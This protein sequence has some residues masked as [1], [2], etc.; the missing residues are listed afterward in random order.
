MTTVFPISSATQQSTSNTPAPTTGTNTLN[1][2]HVLA[3]ARCGV[4]V[5]GPD[6][7]GGQHAVPHPDCAVHGGR[8][9]AE[10]PVV[11]ASDTDRVAGARGVVDDRP[12]RSRTRSSKRRPTVS[13]HRRHRPSSSSVRGSLPSDAAVGATA[14]CV[15]PNVYTTAGR[16]GPARPRRSRRPTSGW[17]VQASSNGATIGP[18][19][20]VT[21]DA[22]GDHHQRRHH[23]SRRARSTASAA[24]RQPTGPRPASSLGFGDASDPTRLQLSASASTI[25]VV[26]QNGNDGKTATG[27]VTGVHMTADGPQLVIGGQANP[28]HVGHRRA[29]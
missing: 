16:E 28:L 25:G 24:P 27:I 21:F 3:A 5:P 15:A 19:Q 22:G 7:P 12:Q 9:A 8:D 23:D 11:A 29:A 13:R 26:E 20:H 2:Q 10:D 4:E 18:A 1:S 6:E 17:I 14:H